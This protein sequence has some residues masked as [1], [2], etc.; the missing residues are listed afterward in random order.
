MT[1]GIDGNALGDDAIYEIDQ[2]AKQ[3]LL[4]NDKGGY[5]VPTH[6]L[7]PYQWNWDSAFVALGFATFDMGRAVTEI[8]TL[9]DAQWENGMV[10]HI[11]FR[12]DDPSYFPGPSVWRSDTAPP[13][14]GISQPPVAASIV[15]RLWRRTEEPG[16]RKRLA[17]LFPKLMAY[18]RWFHQFRDP[19]ERGVVLATHPWET[20][21]DNTPEW[22]APLANVDTSKVEPYE[23]RDLKHADASMR[24]TKEEYDGYIALVDFGRDCGWDAEK[25][26]RE[27][28]FRV[29]D[30]GMSMMLLRADR[31]LLHLAEELNEKGDEVEIRAWI[32]RGEKGADYLWDDAIGAFCCRD[33]ITDRPSG[34]VTSASFLCFYADVGNGRQRTSMDGHFKRIAASARY[35]TPSFDPDNDKFDSIRYWR[36]PVWAVVNF[37][38]ENGLREQGRKDFADRV[39]TDTKALIAATGFAE[40]FCPITG[41][42]SGG[43]NF[44]WTAAMWLA[45]ARNAKIEER[46]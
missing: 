8:E 5:T 28:P 43:S 14:S 16:I 39:A 31:D 33:V 38:I 36:G 21:R 40:S 19:D 2:R 7:Y 24:P 44:S 20:G 18:H 45:W 11:V 30:V 29:A 9:F 10:P 4:N 3:I 35:M 37:M 25:I 26:S 1:N 23:R 27:N 6:G 41:R 42:A 15:W 46:T 13:S 34:F 12:V 32:A 22:D 17:A